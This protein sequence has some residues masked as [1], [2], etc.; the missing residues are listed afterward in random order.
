MKT[1]L[2]NLLTYSVICFAQPIQSNMAIH[3]PVEAQHG[4]VSTQ[5]AL[6]SKVG[7]TVLKNGGNAIDAAVAIGFTLAVTLPQAGNLGGGGFMMIHLATQNR[8]IAIDFRETAPKK[9]TTTMFIDENGDVDTN[10]SRFSI[11]ASGTPGSVNGLLTAL[12]NYGT[13]SRS[14]VLTPA[15]N[16][17][18][19]GFTVSSYL[20]HSLKKAQKHLSKQDYAANIFYPNGQ[21]PKIGSKLKQSDLANTLKS[22]IRLGKRGFYD[23]PVATKIVSFM[24][25]NNGLIRASDLKNYQSIERIPIHG[26][27]HGYDIYSMPPPSSGGVILLQILKLIEPYP[28]KKWG[29]NSAKSMHIMSEAMSLAYADRAEWLGDSDFVAVPTKNL[30]AAPYIRKRRKLMSHKRHKPSVGVTFGSPIES[31]ET[32]HFSVVDQWGNAVS[33]TTTLNFSYGSGL[34]IPGTGVLLNNEM[35]DFSAKPG[36][37][38]AYGLLG[39]EKNKIEPNKRMLSSMTPTIVLKNGH[40]FL[41]TGSPGGSRIIT[42]VAQVISNVIDHNMNIAEATHAPRFHHQWYP[43]HIRIEHNGFSIDTIKLLTK[44]HHKIVTKQA[45]GGTQS[46][47]KINNKLFGSSDSRKPSGLTIGY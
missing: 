11:L 8:T 38:N 7:L 14:A 37:P 19:R 21:V 2:F 24:K 3:H 26:T 22:I 16:L 6:A 20:H 46:I 9:A 42:T 25:K 12:E 1:L 33:V 32:T 40:T 43:D 30:L 10:L 5:E 47:I 28:L 45:M 31:T 35:D 29:H 34:A 36:V 39:N 4:M 23:G 18:K 44:K 13:Q 27:Y 41:V 15:Y 17:A